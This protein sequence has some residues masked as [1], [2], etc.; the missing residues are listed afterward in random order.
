MNII[1]YDY[2]QRQRA[3]PEEENIIPYKNLYIRVFGDTTKFIAMNRVKTN[4]P[5]QRFYSGVADILN[6]YDFFVYIPE[7]IT[8]IGEFTYE[9]QFRIKL[10]YNQDFIFKVPISKEDFESIEWL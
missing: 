4:T 9:T 10:S 7:T 2:Y 1:F 5:S 3:G 8:D 6:K